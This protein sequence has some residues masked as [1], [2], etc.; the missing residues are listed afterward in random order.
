MGKYVI[1]NKELKENLLRRQ[2]RNITLII[3]NGLRATDASISF[4]F[5][6]E[7]AANMILWQ[8]IVV[9]GGTNHGSNN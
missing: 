9:R 6:L 8:H 5:Q 4:R 2:K 1:V 7:Y 3:F